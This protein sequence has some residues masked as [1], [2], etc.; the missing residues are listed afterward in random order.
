M[1]LIISFFCFYFK[2]LLINF[3]NKIIGLGFYLF[4]K[5]FFLKKK[6]KICV[7]SFFGKFEGCDSDFRGKNSSGDELN[8]F[9]V[10]YNTK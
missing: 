4:F 9:Y 2:F 6:E 10:I 1:L 8:D 5:F 7:I 3:F